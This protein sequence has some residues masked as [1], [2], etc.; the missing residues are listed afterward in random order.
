MKNR[1]PGGGV[2]SLCSRPLCVE[3][4]MPHTAVA[5]LGGTGQRTK[6]WKCTEGCVANQ[7]PSPEF[8]QDVLFWGCMCGDV[9]TVQFTL[10]GDFDTRAERPNDG[11]E[12]QQ[13][14]LHA[15]AEMGSAPCLKALLRNLDKR[16]MSG[17]DGIQVRG[18][19]GVLSR[20]DASGMT[21]L[22]YAVFMA[23]SERTGTHGASVDMVLFLIQQGAALAKRN[24]FY[25]RPLAY[26]SRKLNEDLRRR[27]AEQGFDLTD[28][29]IPGRKKSRGK[30]K[31]H[32]AAGQGG[33]RQGIIRKASMAGFHAGGW[34]TSQTVGAVEKMGNAALDFGDL[35]LAKSAKATLSLVR[36]GTGN[37]SA[38]TARVVPLPDASGAA[39]QAKRC[40]AQRIQNFFQVRE[41]TEE[42]ISECHLNPLEAAAFA[43]NACVKSGGTDAEAQAI[44]RNEE[45]SWVMTAVVLVL[46]RKFT[47]E[48]DQQEKI[49]K[50]LTKLDLTVSVL[51]LEAVFPLVVFLL[52]GGSF[53]VI[54]KLARK[55]KYE[56]RLSLPQ[57]WEKF[58]YDP[59]K[60]SI[61]DPLLTRDYQ[62][63]VW[64]V[65]NS[66]EA[67][68]RGI[69]TGEYLENHIMRT[70]FSMHSFG[71]K[72][73]V[74]LRE[75]GAWRYHPFTSWEEFGE[76]WYV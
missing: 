6:R 31:G 55:W 30:K 43:Y 5:G 18:P 20:P 53:R 67:G 60:A 42:A 66:N 57:Y 73:K 22:H 19:H 1:L 34:L 16:E 54:R 15:C 23:N 27:S 38:S 59:T 12:T 68:K 62:L 75:F 50:R 72:R 44:A 39:G 37:P 47:R 24:Q 25:I 58:P 41:Q 69:R 17:E 46:D 35:V 28:A 63:V 49:I 65:I 70:A 11:T 56:M 21:P 71:G 76:W 7:R 74:L 36:I 51:D 14:P 4:R 13:S 2:C 45:V 26:A 40:R 48:N 52:V 61:F 3:C 29:L 64:Q 8:I 9:E 33:E 32:G 10:D